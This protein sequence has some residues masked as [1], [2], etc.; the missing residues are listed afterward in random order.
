MKN[1][2]IL[3]MVV[4][5]WFPLLP[6]HA[7]DHEFITVGSDKRTYLIHVPPSLSAPAPLLFAFHGAGGTPIA[8]SKTSGFDALADA[9]G[10]IVVYPAGIQRRWND[11]RITYHGAADDLGFV[12]ALIAKVESQYQID[13]KRIYAAGMSNGATFTEALACHDPLV[14]AAVAAVSGTIPAAIADNCSHAVA[15]MQIGGTADPVMPFDGGEIHAQG[16]PGGDVLSFQATV[17]HWISNDGCTGTSP[18][19]T[20]A[21]ANN[22]EKT[23]VMMQYGQN[24]RPGFNVVAYKII[25]GGHSWPGAPNK[26][27]SHQISAGQLI[28][29]FLLNQHL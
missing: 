17:N 16:L 20:V 2:V 6:A 12:A 5:I 25:G 28:I 21:P 4:S 19:Q 26:A 24:C 9:H 14:F 3:A 15:V 10:M 23:Q 18:F 29:G 8:F 27:A 7:D 22:I 13:P 11:G 1:L